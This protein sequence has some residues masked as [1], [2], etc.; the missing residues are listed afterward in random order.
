M[1][2]NEDTAAECLVHYRQQRR[3]MAEK[4]LKA[5][6]IYRRYAK[7]H[8]IMSWMSDLDLKRYDIYYRPHRLQVK[9]CTEGKNRNSE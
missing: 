8:V 3:K 5:S 1:Q 4:P 7:R 2:L 6:K 9:E